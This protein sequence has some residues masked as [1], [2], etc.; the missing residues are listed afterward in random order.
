MNE[1]GGGATGDYFYHKWQD[2]LKRIRELEE[3]N[4]RISKLYEESQRGWKKA[5]LEIEELKGGAS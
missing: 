3:E 5:L 2:S 4:K 1:P